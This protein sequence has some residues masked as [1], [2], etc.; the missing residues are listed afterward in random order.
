MK[1]KELKFPSQEEVKEN[2]ISRKVYQVLG[3]EIEIWTEYRLM[4]PELRSSAFGNYNSFP[5]T[6]QGYKE[7]V[8]W[9]KQKHKEMVDIL[10]E[11][12]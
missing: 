11:V 12:E 3:N 1:F 8:K 4:E 2:A 5:F 6:K 10:C 9:I 7:A